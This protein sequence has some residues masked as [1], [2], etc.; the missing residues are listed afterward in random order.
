MSKESKIAQRFLESI[1]QE[2]TRITFETLINLIEELEN[3]PDPSPTEI[4]IVESLYHF[5]EKMRILEYNLRNYV[6]EN[7]ENLPGNKLS[8]LYEEIECYGTSALFD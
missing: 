6:K 4:R 3:K 7:N 8:N 5:M 2:P 1:S